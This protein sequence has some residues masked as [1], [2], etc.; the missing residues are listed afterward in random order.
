MTRKMVLMGF[1]A[2]LVSAL[3][4][5]CQT[6]RYND[7]GLALQRQTGWDQSNPPDW[8]RHGGAEDPKGLNVL[9]VGVSQ[10]RATTEGEAINQAYLDALYK[11]G[12][13]IGFRLTSKQQNVEWDK[14][15]ADGKFPWRIRWRRDENY[16]QNAKATFAHAY[17]IEIQ[18][19]QVAA[20]TT[21]KDTWTVQERFGN[22]RYRNAMKTGSFWKAKILLSVSRDELLTR[23]QREFDIRAREV[24]MKLDHA[25]L[26]YEQARRQAELQMQRTHM[27]NDLM[28]D[29]A[30]Q[31]TEL[32]LE[33]ARSQRAL[34]ED[35]YKRRLELLEGPTFNFMTNAV[36]HGFSPEMIRL[37][38]SPPDLA[39]AVPPADYDL[40]NIEA[41]LP[42]I[43][44]VPDV[45]TG[46]GTHFISYQNAPLPTSSPKT[47]P[48]ETPT[49]TDPPLP[50]IPRN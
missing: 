39:S 27:L 20:L 11:V 2:V 47:G 1:L 12:D 44:G 48:P 43:G 46:A 37:L 8:A 25:E 40:P 45:Q 42:N 3:V 32:R 15:G 31:Q 19:D 36:W 17:V 10:E 35:G 14:T 29:Y 30:R 9:F 22:P 16:T 6:V 33:Q 23:V 13:Y 49:S 24:D 4:T 5:G 28:I 34:T 26:V 21:I 50:K 7:Q 41:L 38:S 18:R